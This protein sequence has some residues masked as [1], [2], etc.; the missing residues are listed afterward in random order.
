VIK[1][2][3]LFIKISDTKNEEY[4]NQVSELLIEISEKEKSTFA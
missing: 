2:S 4:V 3:E 1:V